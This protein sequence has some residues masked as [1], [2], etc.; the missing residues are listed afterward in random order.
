M[1]GS[2]SFKRFTIRNDKAA[3]KVGTDAVLLGAAMTLRPEDKTLLDI[4]TGTGVIALMVAQRLENTSSRIL[5]ID[6][7]GPSAEEAAENFADSPWASALTAIHTSLAD[8]RPDRKFD[9]IFSNPPFYDNSLTN[10]DAREATARHTESLSYREIFAFSAEWLQPDGHLSL[11]L[12][13]DQEVAIIRTAA[14][15][16]LYPFR[17]IRVRTTIRKPVR[18]IILEFSRTREKASEE[19]L[20]LQDGSA[21]SAQYAELTREF[22][23]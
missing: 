2:F 17:I 22:Y 9:C 3:L 10:P 20:T 19:S 8:F 5:S 4:G 18:R 6:I 1:A 7:D 21:R 12:P 16:G 13:A 23:L 11:I 15:F 14:S